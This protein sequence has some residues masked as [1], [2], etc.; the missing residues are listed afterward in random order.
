MA[1][2]KRPPGITAL[3]LFFLFGATMSGLTALMLRFP[4][5]VFEPLWRINPRA[6]AGFTA[7][8]AWGLLLMTAVC[9]ACVI[10]ALGL[11]R[12]THWGFWAA[13]LILSV[14]LA[15]DTANALIAGDWRTLIGL[16]IGGFMLAYLFR[17]RRIFER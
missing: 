9:V 1:P 16:P 17:R 2:T 7:M 15:G 3:S 5:G 14:N 4:G 13:L 8:G 6:Q 11:W 10:A 12:C